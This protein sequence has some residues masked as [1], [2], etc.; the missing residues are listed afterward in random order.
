MFTSK[1]CEEMNKIS[2]RL[3]FRTCYFLEGINIVET[4]RLEYS[5]IFWHG[6]TY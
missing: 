1:Y 5:D 6:D 2:Q 4:K 3:P